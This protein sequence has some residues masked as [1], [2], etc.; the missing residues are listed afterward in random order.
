MQM[1][2]VRIGCHDNTLAVIHARWIIQEIKRVDSS[3]QPDMIPIAAAEEQ[4]LELPEETACGEEAQAGELER[5]LLESRIDL[6]IYDLKELPQ[7]LMPGLSVAAYSARS[8]VRNTLVLPKG[9]EAPDMGRPI[10]VSGAHCRM[11]AGVLYPRFDIAPIRGDVPSRLKRLDCGDYSALI[12]PCDTL[13]RLGIRNRSSRIFTQQEIVPAAGQGI[14]AIVSREGEVHCYL[15][16]VDDFLSRCCA[17]AERTFISLF[18]D[19]CHNSTAAFAQV[20]D[21]EIQMIGFYSDGERSC[22]RQLTGPLGEARKLGER[23]AEEVKQWYQN[24]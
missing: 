13:S 12:L 9:M 3:C 8:D 1:Q 21:E 23:L 14:L 2:R 20:Q 10:G 17:K 4:V 7:Q 11:Q 22:K 24:G 18:P 6:A 5:A 19:T 15:S 16:A